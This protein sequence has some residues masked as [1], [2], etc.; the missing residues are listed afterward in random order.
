[1]SEV[2]PLQPENTLQGILEIAYEL[3]NYLKAI[4]GMDEF[5]FQTGGGAH[6]TY[7][8][9]CITRKYFQERGELELEMKSSPP[10]SP[11]HAM[12]QRLQQLDLKSSSCRT[13]MGIR[14]WML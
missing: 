7:M 4:S 14:I 8:N 5:S 1:M 13:K 10:S 6:A 3:R 9:A 12:R 2:H 11:T